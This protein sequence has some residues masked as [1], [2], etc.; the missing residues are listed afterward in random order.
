M[1]PA[2]ET[3]DRDERR[4]A[5]SVDLSSGPSRLSQDHRGL[6][7]RQLGIPLWKIYGGVEFRC[8]RVMGQGAPI[9]KIGDLEGYLLQAALGKSKMVIDPLEVTRRGFIMDGLRFMEIAGELGTQFS[10]HANGEQVVVNCSAPSS[11]EIARIT[12]VMGAV[13]REALRAMSEGPNLVIFHRGRWE[14]ERE[15]Q[16]IGVDVCH[17][18]QMP[19]EISCHI[20]PENSLLGEVV[21]SV[22]IV[23]AAV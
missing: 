18:P 13:K 20:L 17:K 6:I 12:A 4:K 2:I 21:Q 1:A 9:T 10:A 8:C 14:E 7:A 15:V 19:A 16:Y 3:K 5:L 23:H 11:A 22:Y